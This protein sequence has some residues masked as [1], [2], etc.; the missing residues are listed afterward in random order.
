MVTVTIW[1]LATAL[2]AWP[3]PKQSPSNTQFG[4]I[5]GI[6]VNAE[7]AP[8]SGAKVYDQP[9]NAVRIGK[10]HFVVT[11]ETGRF[12]LRGVPTGRT[13]VIATKAED[14]Y[15]D[16]RF[17]VYSGDAVLPV[18]EIRTDQTTSGV[19]V[20]LLRRGGLLRGRI[21]DSSS[22]IPVTSSR[23]TLSRVDHPAWSLETDPSSD[24]TFEFVIPARP[25]DFRVTAPGFK[26]W[27][28]AGSQ[29][30]KN[31][32]PLIASPDQKLNIDVELEKSS[33]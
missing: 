31:H 26:T 20:K 29:F 24:G 23:I 18:V 30:S 17:A 1:L 27:T 14:G 15:P 16:A 12:Y 9:M 7:G 32:G 28:Y 25:M 3:V 21:V 2:F 8:I 10:D 5:K 11:D 19:V 6:V 13:M 4:S 33:N 22:R